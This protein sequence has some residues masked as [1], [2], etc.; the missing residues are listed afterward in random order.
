MFDTSSESLD[1]DRALRAIK[2]HFSARYKHVDI[3]F[4]EAL[5][6]LRYVRSHYE[7][8]YEPTVKGGKVVVDDT[9]L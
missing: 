8:G 3:S 7:Q 6:Y 2:F 4:D 1:A 5:R 9:M